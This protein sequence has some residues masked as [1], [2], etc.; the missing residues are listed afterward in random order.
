LAQLLSAFEEQLL[1]D[2]F[3]TTS[4]GAGQVAAA[5]VASPQKQ[6][7]NVLSPSSSPTRSSSSSSRYLH[8]LLHTANSSKQFEPLFT[9]GEYAAT[10]VMVPVML[11]VLC[12]FASVTL[13]FYCGVSALISTRGARVAAGS[14]PSGGGC[15]PDAAVVVQRVR[16]VMRADGCGD[17]CNDECGAITSLFIFYSQSLFIFYS[18][19]QSE[20][21]QPPHRLGYCMTITTGLARALDADC[22][23]KV[24]EV[25]FVML[26]KPV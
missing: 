6:Q 18:Q 12:A 26:N 7:R 15:E 9:S 22:G 1:G 19:S 17:V 5:E 16:Y 20:M 21:L 25:E 14:L 8:T 24:D 13:F 11:P 4:E 2:D 23:G 3:L 10:V